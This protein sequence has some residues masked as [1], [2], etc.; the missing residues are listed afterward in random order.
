MCGITG[1]IRWDNNS[2]NSEYVRIMN[3]KLSHR[4]PDGEGYYNEEYLSLGHKRLSIID[5]H[6]GDQ[7]IFN[8]DRSIVVVFNGEIYNFQE[9]VLSA[10]FKDLLF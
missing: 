1:I 8:E 4:G 5:L 9:F 10:R 2:V 7:P 6:T 3:N